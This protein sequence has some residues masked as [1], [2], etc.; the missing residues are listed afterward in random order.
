MRSLTF[1]GKP[2]D[3][4]YLRYEDIKAGGV[5]KADMAN[6]PSN[7]VYTDDQLPFS[8]SK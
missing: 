5:M 4:T 6:T 2:V 7:T 3:A 8:L 1:N